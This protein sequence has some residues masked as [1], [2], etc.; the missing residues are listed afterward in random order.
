MIKFHDYNPSKPFEVRGEWHYVDKGEVTLNYTPMQGSMKVFLDGVEAT[1]SNSKSVEAGQF[2]IDYS[3]DSDYK[4]ATQKVYF[5]KSDN[6][7]RATFDYSGVSTLIFAKHFNE[8]RDFMNGYNEDRARD[9]LAGKIPTRSGEKL[10][11]FKHPKLTDTTKVTVTA[12]DGV[13]LTVGSVGDLKKGETYTLSDGE[14]F[15]EFEVAAIDPENKTVTAK[16]LK[17]TYTKGH[18]YKTTASVVDGKATVLNGSQTVQWDVDEVWRGKEGGTDAAL[19]PVSAFGD[20]MHGVFVNSSGEFEVE[21]FNKMEYY[22]WSPLE[23]RLQGGFCFKKTT[24]PVPVSVFSNGSISASSLAT[25]N[26]PHFI[27]EAGNVYPWIPEFFFPKLKTIIVEKTV[28]DKKYTLSGA[29][30]PPIWMKEV[31]HFHPEINKRCL[32]TCVSEQEGTILHPAFNEHKEGFYIFRYSDYFKEDDLVKKLTSLEV[33]ACC[34]YLPYFSGA[35][36]AVP[37][38]TTKVSNSNA[39]WV[40]NVKTGLFDYQGVNSV[41]AVQYKSDTNGTTLSIVGGFSMVFDRATN[42]TNSYL[43]FMD[44]KTAEQLVKEGETDGN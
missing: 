23:F 12:V 39:E 9:L 37:M 10:E 38:V 15:E 5:N 7:K 8:I 42:D 13:T 32:A 21:N 40:M 17:N 2:Y 20:N 41:A 34:L 22:M 25:N 26:Y 36:F 14:R 6:G 1:E 30:I 44:K 31:S 28:G 18:I 24:T 35:S 11:V 19:T 43:Y 33:S 16:E 3:A 4:M 29:F 27:D